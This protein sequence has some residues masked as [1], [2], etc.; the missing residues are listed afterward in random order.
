MGGAAG[1]STNA[2]F[3]RTNNQIL[4]CYPVPLGT[5][6]N[7]ALMGY[8]PTSLTTFDIARQG[9]DN[10]FNDIWV[11]TDHADSPIRAY[12]TAG[13]LTYACD[14][15][16]PVRGMAYNYADEHDYVWVSNPESSMIYQIDI[17]PTGIGESG[18][19]GMEPL[20][21]TPSRN[22]FDDTVA[23]VATGTTGTGTIEVFDMTGRILVRS[24]FEGEFE[25]HGTTDDG[26]RVPAGVYMI[27]VADPSGDQIFLTLTRL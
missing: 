11:A 19:P 13:T 8:V 18:T 10:S 9:D 23:L 24:V 12:N 7:P 2:Y 27:R 4:S 20:S 15:V 5:T 3:L 14:L 22:P 21:V 6:S 25:W 26:D 17:S 1:S 16:S